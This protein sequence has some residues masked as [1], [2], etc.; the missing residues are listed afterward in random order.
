MTFKNGNDTLFLTLDSF[1]TIEHV[2]VF[3][4]FSLQ[5]WLVEYSSMTHADI[6]VIIS[7]FYCGKDIL[8]TQILIE[9]VNFVSHIKPPL[10]NFVG[11]HKQSVHAMLL[12]F[13]FFYPW[14]RAER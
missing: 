7:G 8:D 4:T 14:D 6:E 10:G 5:A 3:V 9:R 2:L 12:K 1:D 11:L 13:T